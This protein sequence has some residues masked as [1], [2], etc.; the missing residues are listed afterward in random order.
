MK[1][2]HPIVNLGVQV[3]S[4]RLARELVQLSGNDWVNHPSGWEGCEQ[5]LL[6]SHNGD[7]QD[8]S[9][10]SPHHRTKNLIPGS[11]LEEVISLFSPVGQTKVM[12][13]KAG[14][15]LPEHTDIHPYWDKR[16]RIHI[17]IITN[18][19]V[20]FH[21]D[22]ETVQMEAG[23]CFVLDNARPH[24]VENNGD[25]DRYHLVID[26]TLENLQELV[27]E[28]K[29]LTYDDVLRVSFTEEAKRL[30][31]GVKGSLLVST[32]ACRR[33][34]SLNLEQRQ[35]TSFVLNRP[36]GLHLS[37]AGLFIADAT[38][39]NR[40]AFADGVFNLVNQRPIGD[41]QVHEMAF[42]DV[43][44]RKELFFVNT[45][46]NALS[47]IP[48]DCSFDIRWIPPFIKSDSLEKDRCHLNGLGIHNAKPMVTML[49]P[50][51]EV[52][53]WREDLSQGL[54]MNAFT[55][56]IILDGL[57]MP[58][59]PRQH[60]EDLIFFESGVGKIRRLKVETREVTDIVTDVP[61]F[62]RGSFILGDLLFAGVSQLRPSQVFDKTP[63]AQSGIETYCGILVVNLETKESGFIH[64][65]GVSEVSNLL[66]S[67]AQ[68]I[69]SHDV[70]V[71]TRLQS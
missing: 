20:L 14:T 70:N 37:P 47:T 49:R 28:K 58:H 43:L 54:I 63:L 23:S 32:G 2:S 59:S 48:S 8:N 60:R 9:K 68:F 36:T 40:Y 46:Y 42:I 21:C 17:P 18:T 22:G 44:H 55:N 27:I 39:L 4:N 57:W 33:V 1:L 12:R 41:C 51:A 50:A 5:L 62:L 25:E 11:Y 69:L 67:N 38:T 35:L 52:G 66:H 3:D 16:I 53:G 71:K 56:E 31:E 24:S 26:I 64:F 15:S 7:H 13:L 29:P 10:L 6:I 19:G 34:L 61:G 45:E 30:L 65:E